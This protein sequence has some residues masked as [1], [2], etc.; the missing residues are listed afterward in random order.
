MIA[1]SKLVKKLSQGV[2]KMPFL[3]S[4]R[5]LNH[6]VI[7]RQFFGQESYQFQYVYLNR[8]LFSVKF[9]WTCPIFL[10][11]STRAVSY[12]AASSSTQA[13]SSEKEDVDEVVNQILSAIEIAPNSS[14]EICTFHIEKLCKAKKLSYA[15]RLQQSLHNNH[16]FL[17]PYAYNLLL[18]AAGE[19]NDIDLLQQVFKDALLSG[20]PMNSTSY[21]NLAKGFTKMTD[22]E[23]L[24]RFVRELSELTFYRSATVV[25]RI[26]VSFA[27]CGQVD[28][29]LVVFNHIE[30]L[31]CKPDLVTFNTVLGILGRTS[32]MDEMLQVFGF[33]IEANIV[34][35]IITYNTL[36]NNLQ[37]VGRLDLCLELLKEMSERGIEADLRTYT[38]MIEGF[39]RSGKI[40]QSLRLFNEMKL[41]QI[42][43]SIYIYRSLVNYLKKMGKLELSITLAEEMNAR[44][45]ELVSPKDFKR[46]D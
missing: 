31:K 37:K 39:G 8:P 2:L 23:L 17:S 43:P 44:L 21:I 42:R 25:N 36:L 18:E 20:V 1:A 5:F 26:I 30:T 46:K 4:Y 14:K 12:Q 6:F 10:I 24:L 3:S 29:A 22:S 11:M 45:P 33:M 9:S 27:S 40:E 32:R 16:I 41:K 38:A 34:P 7:K 13:S 15:S 28:K 35:D 19:E